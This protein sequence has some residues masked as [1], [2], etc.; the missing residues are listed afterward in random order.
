MVLVFRANGGGVK[1]ENKTE[2]DRGAFVCNDA[3]DSMDRLQLSIRDVCGQ[4][5]ISSRPTVSMK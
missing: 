5:G 3:A 4:T 2:M 1:G